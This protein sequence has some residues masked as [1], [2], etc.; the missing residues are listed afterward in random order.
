MSS[1]PFK[2]VEGRDG[3]LFLTNDTN[4]SQLQWTGQRRYGPGVL[5]KWRS[6]IATRIELLGSLCPAPYLFVVAPNKESVHPEFL[7]ENLAPS[8]RRPIHD[9]IDAVSDLTRVFWPV[10]ELRAWSLL[11]DVYPKVDTHWTDFGGF[12][13]ARA[14]AARLPGL[15]V[16]SLADC[17]LRVQR[18][19][20]DL[21]SKLAP[22]RQG[23][24]SI[25]EPK[26]ATSRVVFDNG[27]SNNGRIIISEKPGPTRTR[28]LVF[29]D[30][31]FYAILPFLREAVDRLVFIHAYSVDLE[32]VAHERPDFV[33]SETVERFL[34]EPPTP[35]RSFTG[36]RHARLK[37]EALSPED[38]AALERACTELERH[39][40]RDRIYADF[41]R[42]DGTPGGA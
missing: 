40:P 29:G 34:I 5:D 8:E 23:A 25:A 10:D 20:G 11:L 14:L 4:D 38:R 21:G 17:N 42:I 13:I 30:S 3:W 28:G 2:V 1:V 35:A 24:W 12:C 33:L 18:R 6:E 31:F 27:L 26:S 16:P 41:H 7:P 19:T 37:M 15:S 9:F 22:P 39:N 32:I 36:A